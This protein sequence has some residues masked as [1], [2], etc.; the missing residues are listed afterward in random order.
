MTSRFAS[1]SLKWTTGAQNHT[2]KATIN[3]PKSQTIT[4]WYPSPNTLDPPLIPNQHDDY[5][6]A[7]VCQHFLKPFC[8][9]LKGIPP[10]DV[11]HQQS[12][13]CPTEIYG[14]DGSILFITSLWR[15]CHRCVVISY[16]TLEALLACKRLDLTFHIP[17]LSAR[18]RSSLMRT[19]LLCT[20]YTI[21]KMPTKDT[22][23][24]DIEP[25]S[26]GCKA[27]PAFKCYR[28]Q[29]ILQSN[30]LS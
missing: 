2:N 23:L 1:K 5:L 15:E 25:E 13:R 20:I 24:R 29:T 7:A 8:E 12:T 21:V 17:Q 30:P 16:H 11:I 9:V 19:Q 26:W 18:A 22:C 6:R 14:C 10:G 3:C 27:L 28:F 4:W